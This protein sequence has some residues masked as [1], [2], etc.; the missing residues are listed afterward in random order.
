MLNARLSSLGRSDVALLTTSFVVLLCCLYY[1]YLDFSRPSLRFVLHPPTW[2]VIE[3]DP[4]CK[5][6]PAECLMVNDQ[7]LSLGTV[8]RESVAHDRSIPLFRDFREQPHV[9]HPVTFVRNGIERTVWIKPQAQTDIF[10]TSSLVWIFPAVF[11]LAGT[12]AVIFLRPRDAQWLV[13]VSLYYSV[14]LWGASGLLSATQ[15]GYSAIVFRFVIWAFAPLLLH[16]HLILPNRRFKSMER[17]VLIPAYVAC[18]ALAVVD[19]IANLSQIWVLVPICFSIACSISLLLLRLIIDDKISH[20]IINRLLLFGIG[21]GFL[22][23]MQQVLISAT[24]TEGSLGSSLYA[25]LNGVLIVVILPFWPFSYLYALYRHGSGM[26]EFRAN[27]ILSSY[28]FYSLY[29]TLFVAVFMIC[30]RWVDEPGDQ[31]Q[32]SL[33]ISLIFLVAAGPLRQR[34]ERLVDRHIYGIH[35]K[36]HQVLSRFAELIPSS[37]DRS[38]LR[39][40]ICTEILPTLMVRRSALYAMEDGRVTS[41]YEQ[42]LVGELPTVEELRRLR[43]R[44][45]PFKSLNLAADERFPWVRLCI[46]LA[47]QDRVIGLWLL[48]RR[49]PDDFYPRSDIELL[50]Q[51]GNQIAPV[52]E[53]VRLVEMARQEVEENRR[54]QEQLVQ[55]QKMEAIGRLSAGVAHDFNNLLSVILGYS[56]LL[57]ARYRSDES[58]NKYLSDIRD[59]GNRAASLTK[60]LLAFSRQQVMEARTMDLNTVIMDVEKMLRRLTGE[61]IEVQTE[62]AG[63]LPLVKIDPSQMG[64]VIMNLAVNARDAMPD[65]GSI[66]I[67]TALSVL[68]ELDEDPQQGT[69]PPG[70]YVSMTI[71]D[72]GTGIDPELLHRIFEPYFTTKELGKGTGLGLSMV[73]GI[74]NQSKGYI[75]VSSSL[76]TGSS[77]RILLPA[78]AQESRSLSEESSSFE[79]SSDIGDETILVVEDEDSVRMVAC[80][81]L[82]SK[83]YRVLRAAGGSEALALF[84]S[85]KSNIDLLLTDVIMPHMKGP[86]LAARLLSLRPEMKVVF[87]SGYNEE[88]ILGKRL[89]ED[90][91]RLI[92][93]P[94]TPNGLA[95]QIRQALDGP[96]A[97]QGLSGT[98]PHS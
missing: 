41:I 43:V 84:K 47:T 92:Q 87:M 68:K 38:N 62:L 49:D 81:I 91:T 60:Q 37:F 82:E 71:R 8:D 58:L 21:V 90:G 11:W 5:E 24:Q 89:G 50:T 57:I 72:T 70:H 14:A 61:H 15:A 52:I 55:S 98:S 56:S 25:T 27:R 96:G 31:L 26:V 29:I 45:R 36:P 30:S 12:L 65:G 88:S 7:V 79:P 83:G 64:Q 33:A 2:E 48:G 32:L 23:I 59:A 9:D 73:Y 94:F 18:G 75:R 4:E 20:R 10:E 51:L 93:K 22:P 77:F 69:I 53:N 86:E 74:I 1:A 85:H 17:F 78:V 95:K 80:E 54:L 63:G 66:T 76:G 13:L 6:L 28:G 3:V 42:D 16:L 19:Y 35:Y 40:V 97:A 39:R 67:S 34:I 46:P 44:V